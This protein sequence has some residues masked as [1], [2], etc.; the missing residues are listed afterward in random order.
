M[1]ESRVASRYAKALLDLS[2]EKGVLEE[3]EKD[4]ELFNKICHEN[5][6]FVRVMS[7]PIIPHDKK[8]AILNKLLKGK[9]NKMTLLI[10]G[11]ISQKNRESYL[12]HIAKEFIT[13]YK[14]YKGIE[15]AEVTTTFPLT[16]AQKTT[17]INIIGG[18]KGKKVDL[19]EKRD[20]SIIG[21]YI[22][23]VGDRQIDESIKFKLQRLKS[24]FK[25]NPYIAKY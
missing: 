5:P 23:K 16:D 4:M 11:I 14:E 19:Q 22:L 6:L 13:Q 12:F 17:F 24:K 20:E 18:L 3:V 1:H 21:G 25:D 8:Q 9:V 7:N 15:T 10:F 2:K